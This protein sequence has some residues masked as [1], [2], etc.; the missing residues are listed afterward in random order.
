VQGG[1]GEELLDGRALPL[2]QGFVQLQHPLEQGR[3]ADDLRD[4]GGDGLLHPLQC[5][6]LGGQQV[7]DEGLDPGAVLQGTG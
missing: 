5:H 1:L 7:E 2:G 4:E 3:F 6:H